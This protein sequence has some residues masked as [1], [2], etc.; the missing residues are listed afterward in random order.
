[1]VTVRRRTS[2][3]DARSSRALHSTHSTDPPHTAS[4]PREGR[5]AW[6]LRQFHPHALDI[7]AADAISYVSVF[8]DS[9]PPRDDRRAA[10]ALAALGLLLVLAGVVGYFVVVFR[11]GAWLPR[12]RNDAVPNWIFVVAGLVV[13]MLAMTRAVRG[14][15][16]VPGI[17]LGLN[18]VLAVAFAGLLYVMPVVPE[19][20]GPTIGAAAPGFALPDQ[21]GKPVRLADFRGKPLLLVFYR[22]FW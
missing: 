6:S 10:L 12:V 17:L 18:V 21:T 13:S 8:P 9:S 1:V 5:A 16:L 7:R 3:T 15:R 22:G 4:H 2:L 14:R 11:F 20:Q 19:A